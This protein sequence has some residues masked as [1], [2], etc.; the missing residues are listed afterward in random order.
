MAVRARHSGL[1]DATAADD[2]RGGRR[3]RWPG[4]DGRPR[5]TWSPAERVSF[6]RRIE[7]LKIS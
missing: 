4:D 1:A 7:S 6:E 3:D 2:R 5:L